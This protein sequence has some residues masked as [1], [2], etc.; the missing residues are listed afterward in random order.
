MEKVRIQTILEAVATA[1]K[2]FRKSFRGNVA[3]EE[4][5]HAFNC[6][7]QGSLGEYELIYDYIW[8]EDTLKVDGRTTGY[9]PQRGDT[10]IMDVSV[11]KGGT[12]CDVCRTFFVSGVSAEQRRAFDTVKASLRMGGAVL[13]SGA[14]ACDIYR[15]VDRVFAKKGKHLIHHA[16]HKI[17]EMPL[18]QPQF[19]QDREDVLSSGLYTIESGLYEN[20]GIRLENDFLVGIDGATDLFEQMM[21][22]K[23]E[24]YILDE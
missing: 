12:W 18:M 21:P 2:A 1:Y 4:L 23:I 22:L 17:G 13:K 9:L 15:A 19:L 10:L 6:S 16:G 3:T 24:E 7:L 20:F 11:G 8:G 14:R 5:L